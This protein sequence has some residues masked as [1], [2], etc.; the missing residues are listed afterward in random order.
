MA[1][2]N[3]YN[4]DTDNNKKNK[5][6]PEIYVPAYRTSSPE[7]LD[8]SSLSYSYC[9]DGYLQISI[10][11]LKFNDPNSTKF[12]YDNDNSIAIRLS[13]VKASVFAKEIRYLLAHEDTVNNVGVNTSTGSLIIFSTGKEL[14]VDSKCLIIRKLD[15]NGDVVNTYAYQ[16][17]VNPK[18][19]GV[20]NFDEANKTFERTSY[21]NI[22]IENLLMVLDNFKNAMTGGQA[23]ANLYYGR[24]EQS[25]I[26]T[27]L[28]LI[29]DKL[30]IENSREYKRMG[31][32]NSFFGN[33]NNGTP[34]QQQPEQP[35]MQSG[36]GNLLEEDYE[37]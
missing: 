26:N 19:Y 18:L 1:L 8:P 32:T 6:T 7:G 20:R 15:D 33:P 16:F 24:F 37:D 9:S 23:Y 34:V 28:G 35:Q 3:N 4:T 30:G 31:R 12:T 25:K 10:T 14:G 36:Y 29:M 21:P 17:K 13:P 5:Y 27:K 2:G 11:P 22:E